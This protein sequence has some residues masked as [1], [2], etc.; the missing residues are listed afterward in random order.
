VDANFRL[1]VSGDQYD[2]NAVASETLPSGQ[3]INLGSGTAHAL[4]ITL[5]PRVFTERATAQFR[6]CRTAVLRL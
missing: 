6:E 3:V 2:A 5:K 4:R 1:N